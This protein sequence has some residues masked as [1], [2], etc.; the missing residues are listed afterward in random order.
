MDLDLRENK[1]NPTEMSKSKRMIP[2]IIY[3]VVVS[4]SDEGPAAEGP[5]VEG[6]GVAL[7]KQALSVTNCSCSSTVQ[8]E[9][10]AHRGQ[11]SP[12]LHLQ[13]C[14]RLF[15]GKVTFSDGAMYP[16]EHSLSLTGWHPSGII[17]TPRIVPSSCCIL[18]LLNAQLIYI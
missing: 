3:V 15:I 11:A 4:L 8:A 6:P 12:T 9:G 2:T 17:S 13:H 5:A 14:F 18:V 7:P 10:L 1:K 16:D